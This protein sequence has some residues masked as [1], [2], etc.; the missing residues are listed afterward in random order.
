[1]DPFKKKQHRASN[2]VKTALL[3]AGISKPS[4]CV[5]ADSWI[6][7]CGRRCENYTVFVQSSAGGEPFYIQGDTV[8]EAVRNMLGFLRPKAN[9]VASDDQFE[10]APF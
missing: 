8:A 10:T 4:V 2:I 9:D 6:D 1:M 7:G 5:T 3:R